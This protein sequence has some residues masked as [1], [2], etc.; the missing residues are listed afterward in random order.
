M[1]MKRC[2]ILAALFGAAFLLAGCTD[3][4]GTN[5]QDY[6]KCAGDEIVFGASDKRFGTRELATNNNFNHKCEIISLVCLL[7]RCR[8]FRSDG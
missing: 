1:T 7:T 5:S 6:H 8:I 4:W 2:Y 3:E